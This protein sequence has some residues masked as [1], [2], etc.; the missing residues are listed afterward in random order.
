MCTNEMCCALLLISAAAAASLVVVVNLVFK[1]TVLVCVCHYGFS[2]QAVRVSSEA[3]Q[4]LD[5]ELGDRHRP[6]SLQLHEESEL[7]D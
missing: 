5:E 2:R 4:G 6:V 7:A 1:A 3:D